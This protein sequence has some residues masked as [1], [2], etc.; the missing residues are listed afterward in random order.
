MQ[1]NENQQKLAEQKTEDN[2]WTKVST[3]P[4]VCF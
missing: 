1:M 4:G 3:Y 2:E